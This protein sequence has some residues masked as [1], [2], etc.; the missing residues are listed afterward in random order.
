MSIVSRIRA[1]LTGRKQHDQAV[2]DVAEPE[3]LPSVEQIEAAAADYTE[4]SELARQGAAL[5]RR[6]KKVL[7]LVPAGTYGTV[8]VRRKANSRIVDKNAMESMLKAEGKT[9]PMM[10]RATSLV[11]EIAEAT[12]VSPAENPA[13][14]AELDWS[15]SD[16]LAEIDAK[17]AA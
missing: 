14:A 6:A 11:V 15:M 17:L 5:K 13:P 9:L 4:G 12:A 2:P 8:T 1:A 16:L 10:D 3:F 7:D